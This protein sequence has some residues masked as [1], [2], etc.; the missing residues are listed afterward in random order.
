MLVVHHLGMSQSDRIVWLCEELG[1]PYEL[2]RYERDAETRLAPPEYRA[3]HPAGTA[4]VITDGD[5]V[6]GESGAVM[7][8]IVARYGGGWLTLGPDD[9]DY[10]D[11]LYWYH[12]GNGS[13]MPAMMMVAGGEGPFNELMRGRIDRALAHLDAHLGDGRTWLAGEEFTLAD[14][15]NAF[16]LTIMRSFVAIDISPYPNIGPYLRRLVDR[17]GY[18]A[19]MAKADPDIVPNIS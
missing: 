7:D 9:A 6:L 13:L 8:Y 2:R 15:I 11:F 12:F 10:T 19:A 4:P 3:L 5:L 18:R 1:I 17:P 14:I 16:P